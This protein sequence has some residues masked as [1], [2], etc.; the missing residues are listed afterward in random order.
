ME[1][2]EETTQTEQ[3]PQL[4]ITEEMRSYIYDM[5]KWAHLLAIVGFVFSSFI[6]LASFGVDS[7][8]NDPKLSAAMGKSAVSSGGLTTFFLVFAIA[9]FYPSFLMHRYAAK[10]KQGVL[11]GEQE[12]LDEA[13]RRIKALFKYWGLIALV[14]MSLYLLFAIIGAFGVVPG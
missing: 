12:K 9:I 6:F 11:Y 4:V 14:F 2:Q 8:M 7:A 1:N 3:F 10:A 13:F 5:A